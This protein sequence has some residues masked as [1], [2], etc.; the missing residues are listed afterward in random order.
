MSTTPITT[1]T[2]TS[3]G[4]TDGTG[5]LSSLGTGSA[6]QIT[7]L[8]SGLNTN[9]IIDELMAIKQ[10]PVTDLQNQ[11]SGLTALNTQLTTIQTS[12]QA[13]ANDAQ[14]LEDPSLFSTSQ[15]VSSTDPAD[16][17]GTTSTGAGVGGYEV[18]VTQL[19]NSAQRTFAFNSPATAETITIGPPVGSPP[20]PYTTSI[21]AGESIQD[22]VNSINSDSSAPVY[23]AATG[24]G[25][26]VL[27]SRATGG[28]GSTDNLGTDFIPVTDSGGALTENTQLARAGQDANYTLDGGKTLTSS[29]NTV[30]GAIAGVTLTLNGLT[31]GPATINVGAPTPS[32]S[33][34]TAAVQQFV[35][36]YNSAITAISTQLSQ[37]PSSTAPT[38]GTLYNDMDLTSLLSTM[39]DAMY[40]PGSGLPNGMASLLDIGVST[41]ATTGT[42]TPSASAIAGDLTINSATLA[43][44]IQTNPTG[45][46]SV[47]E[48]FSESF[49]PVV[50]AESEAGGNIDS[51]I[52]GDSSQITDLTN[53][54]S[55]MQASLTDQQAQLTQQ[56]AAL[57]ATLSTNQSESSWLTSQISALPPV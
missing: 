47:L 34:I 8:A 43:S 15:T 28:L 52:Q 54:I 53:Q 48:S 6:M 18:D 26:V 9:Q 40:A 35:T 37:V 1:S 57:E 27:S 13:V 31:N 33:S 32:S 24:T 42:G 56:Y 45:V 44:A 14:A 7:G 39:R 46:Q 17:T 4:T 10:Q 49:A 5:L 2:S 30:T 25:T 50:M 41:G 38:Q 55:N 51:R 16:I 29:S 22:F 11:E 3:T 20:A 23:A 19:A 12:L 21:T 36:D